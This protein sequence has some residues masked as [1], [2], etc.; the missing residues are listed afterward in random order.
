LAL[1]EERASD[2]SRFSVG[3]GV[4]IPSISRFLDDLARS[5]R[6]FD[7]IA[8][9]QRIFDRIP[10]PPQWL[11]DDL[12]KTQ[13]AFEDLAKARQWAIGVQP[14]QT[15][16]VLATSR[17]P[18]LS[19]VFSDFAAQRGRLLADLEVRNGALQRS[20]LF[21]QMA[22]II[23][24][25]DS[26]GR[27]AAT[28]SYT[29]A[30]AGLLDT[31][32]R[33]GRLQA[34]IADISLDMRSPI[35][36][37]GVTTRSSSL[38]HSYLDGLPA[39]P[40]LRRARTASQAG[41]AQTGLLIAESLTAPDLDVEIG[42]DLAEDLVATVLEPWQSGPVDARMALFEALARLDPDLPDWLKAAWEDVVRDGP[43]AASKVAHCVVECIDR[44]LRIAAPSSDVLA[45][46]ATMPASKE[47]L[48]ESGQPTRRAKIMFVMRDRANR[49]ARLAAA[50]VESL[51][52]LVQEVVN[53]LQSVKHSQAPSI[54]V[55]QGWL[56]AAEGSLS[57][58]FLRS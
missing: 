12:T 27:F 6:I 22:Q 21:D 3:Q 26:L 34:E 31:L 2:L 13:R 9:A 24:A 49:D 17:I 58:L 20:A 40:I 48:A 19:S 4:G 36:L 37:R 57:Q 23:S 15:E 54:A 25:Q 45:Y 29:P 50:Q 41:D 14:G 11:I 38:Y 30:L 47:Y 56:L 39:R 44:A 28:A 10:R 53:N 52:N 42:E 32:S 5:G 16:N 43:K 46:L 51:S 35:L 8:K 33:Y 55:M 7:D 1:T 18:D